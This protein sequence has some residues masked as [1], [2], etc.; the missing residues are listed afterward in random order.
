MQLAGHLEAVEVGQATV[1]QHQG[2]RSFGS[3]AKRALAVF[4]LAHRVALHLERDAQ[5]LAS[6]RVVLDDQDPAFG[7]GSVSRSSF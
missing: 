5:H 4:G 3:E 1:H 7:H 6:R 2:R